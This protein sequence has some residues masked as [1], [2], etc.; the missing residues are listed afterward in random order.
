MKKTI[1]VTKL[2]LLFIF[3]WI[4]FSIQNS[5]I[6]LALFVALVILLH[7]AKAPIK[8]RLFAIIPVGITIIIFEII[9]Y[10]SVSLQERFLYGFIAGIK[11]ILISLS[12]LTFLS[13]TSLFALIK[14]FDFLPQDT[15]LILLITAYL[16]PTI[17]SEAEKI[18]IVQ[19]SRNIKTN[20][21]SSLPAI[22]VPLLH[23]VFQRAETISLT[24][25]SR[26][27]QSEKI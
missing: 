10:T 26:G 15:L 7:I 23:R 27:Y 13:Y 22:V 5:Y 20:S 18:N 17:F 9:F 21:F 25:L 11:I 2:I 4:V 14:L 12:V 3:N 6:L 16:I 19:K 1:T 24:I 8:K